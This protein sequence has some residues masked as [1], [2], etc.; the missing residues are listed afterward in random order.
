MRDPPTATFDITLLFSFSFSFFF[1][2]F[3]LHFSFFL[4]L[5]FLC[6]SLQALVL[7]FFFLLF[8]PF[9][10][11]H[12]RPIQKNQKINFSFSILRCNLVNTHT[13]RDPL[14][15]TFDFTL[16]F[17]FSFSFSF[18][19]LSYPLFFLFVS[20]LSLFFA[21]SIKHQFFL[22]FSFSSFSPFS[23]QTH[24]KNQETNFFF[25]VLRYKHQSFLS[26]FFFFFLFAF[27]ISNPSK[28]KKKKIK[29]QTFISL[30]FATSISSFFLSFFFSSFS[31]FSS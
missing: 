22:S 20:L 2:F 10:L 17:S 26:F 4:S 23:S 15:T 12:L 16:L 28:K 27:L 9:R 21:T 30:L 7:S 1:F 18:F 24:K 3:L 14:A 19:C 25:S 29:K 11:S 31:P 6:S 13:L 8:L 5:F